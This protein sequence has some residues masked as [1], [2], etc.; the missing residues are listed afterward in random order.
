MLISDGLLECS[1]EPVRNRPPI[2]ETANRCLLPLL[3]FSSPS[4][5]FL[6]ARGQQRREGGREVFSRRLPTIDRSLADRF[7]LL[8]RPATPFTH[9][10][11]GVAPRSNINFAATTFRHPPFLPLRD[12]YGNGDRSSESSLP[13]WETSPTGEREREGQPRFPSFS[14]VNEEGRNVVKSKAFRFYVLFF[15]PLSG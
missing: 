8:S 12:P 7:H 5:P 14:S 11:E 2:D 1:A 3:S 13:V 9:A 10:P 4:P 15:Y 6:P